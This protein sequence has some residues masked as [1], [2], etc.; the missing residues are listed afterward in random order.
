MDL[1]RTRVGNTQRNE[2]VNLLSRAL[3]EGYLDLSEYDQ[4]ITAANAA[5]TAD[6]LVAQTE[7]LPDQLRWHPHRAAGP[8]SAAATPRSAH[9]ATITAL[10]L[11]VAS[12][13]TAI[14]FGMGGLFAIAAMI[15]SR[16]GLRSDRDHNLALVA[17]V[18]GCLGL[19]LSIGM[20]LLFIFL[21]DSSP[22]S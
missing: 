14:C 22:T 2:V 9:A 7:D 10:V 15:L 3:E 1:S 20:L 4:R 16:P 18:L 13:P 6:Q 21:P 5:K 11:A 17:L 19:L 8:A 12:L